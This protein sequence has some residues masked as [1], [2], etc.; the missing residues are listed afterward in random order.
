MI[1][2]C[3]Y[4]PCTT[5]CRLCSRRDRA[6]CSVMAVDV[7]LCRRRD[8]LG[9]LFIACWWMRRRG[10][11]LWEGIRE[12]CNYNGITCRIKTTVSGNGKRQRKEGRETDAALINHKAERVAADE[13]SSG[14]E[15]RRNKRR[16]A[17]RSVGSS[18]SWAP[19]PPPSP[20]HCSVLE[21][22]VTELGAAPST[23]VPEFF[24]R[25]SW[26]LCWTLLLLLLN[27]PLH[28]QQHLHLK[29]FAINPS[30]VPPLLSSLQ[31]L[32]PVT[33]SPCASGLI[34]YN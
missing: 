34:G 17:L 24:F 22:T 4:H 6:C 28:S 16:T 23:G 19:R 13:S 10:A 31:Q 5:T 8:K 12:I 9:I 25:E 3:F 27:Q 26:R 18:A 7:F 15:M 21:W 14:A 1:A 20:R 32:F 30:T 2:Q 33:F 29:P 11:N